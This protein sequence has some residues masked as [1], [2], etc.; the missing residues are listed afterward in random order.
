MKE[1]TNMDFPLN[2]LFSRV[3]KTQILV[4]EFMLALMILTLLLL[5]Y[6]T[7]LLKITTDIRMMQSIVVIW[8]LQ[9]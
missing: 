1:L 8:T 3:A 4:L 9:N 5:I 2:R 7:K 6:L